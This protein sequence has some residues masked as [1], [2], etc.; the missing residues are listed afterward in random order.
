MDLLIN[1][2]ILAA[3]F[4]GMA[5]LFAPCCI[6]ILLP[7]YFASIFR[8]RSRIFV[9]TFVYFIGMLTVFLPLA[10]AA[11]SLTRLLSHYHLGIFTLM[12]LVLIA[13]GSVLILGIRL[14]LPWKVHPR[15]KGTTVGSVYGLGVISGISTTCCAPVLAGV[16]AL[17]SLP[18]SW[19][20]AAAFGLAY[21]LGMVAPLFVMA[22]FA[23][24]VNLV[25][26]IKKR[27]RV[28]TYSIFGWKRQTKLTDLAVGFIYIG[29]GA[30]LLWR[31]MT[32]SISANHSSL[33]L[34]INIWTTQI[35][36]T[37]NDFTSFI[38][39]WAWAGFFVAVLVA[40]TWVAL[41][42][43]KTS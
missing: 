41:K 38:P 6:S 43:E 32:G 42:E 26:R 10:L 14:K 28:L 31:L 18:G 15:L 37:V 11:S 22:L 2:S 1:F 16:V 9:M 20:L 29:L 5:G 19:L 7:G 17:S 34:N 27:N 23:D 24:K 21:T 39:Q 3:F 13:M 12:S 25:E 8:Q 36:R 35:V 33:Q 4:A 30:V 40:I